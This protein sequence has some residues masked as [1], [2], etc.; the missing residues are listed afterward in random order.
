MGELTPRQKIAGAR[1]IIKWVREH[2]PGDH[3]LDRCR[4]IE[5]TC[6]LIAGPEKAPEFV[7]ALD[8]SLIDLHDTLMRV[9]QSEAP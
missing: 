3:T 4:N 7:I 8:A 1:R 5:H 9:E 2:A 6:R